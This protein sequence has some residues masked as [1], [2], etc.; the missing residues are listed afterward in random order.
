MRIDRRWIVLIGLASGVCISNSFARFAYGVILPAMRSDLGW[1]YGEA[2]WINTANALGYV[3][4]AVVAFALIRKIGA[5]PLFG[6]GLV[7]TS[8]SLVLTGLARE[9]GYLTVWRVLAGIGGAPVFIAGGA[10]AA[11]LFKEDSRKNALA[12]AGYFSGAGG[13]MVLVG[14]LLP[15]ILAGGD[16]PNWPLSWIVLGGMSLAM[17]PFAIWSATQVEMA[18]VQGSVG[19]PLP[20]T[21]MVPAL[22]AYGVF[23]F[24]YIVYLTFIAEWMLATP[25]LKRLQAEVWILIG[26]GIIVSPFAWRTILARSFSTGPLS[27]VCAVVAVACVVP[28]IDARPITMIASASLFG[29]ALFIGPSA[30]TSFTRKNLLGACRGPVH[31]GLCSRPVRRAARR[32]AHWRHDG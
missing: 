24:G 20:I 7:L 12:V 28:I 3:I 31:S 16:V 23:A 13:G 1:T 4:G 11:S 30:V 14:V 32:R 25:E 10:M 26:L 8:F 15:D 27:M 17:V 6:W 2:G 19:T 5:K 22:T 9:I 18:S 21:S 29:L